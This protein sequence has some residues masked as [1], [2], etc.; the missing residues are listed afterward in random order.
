LESSDHVEER[1]MFFPLASLLVYVASGAPIEKDRGGSFLCQ[2]AYSIDEAPRGPVEPYLPQP[3]DIFLATDRS[4]IIR[5][6]HCLATSGAPHHSGIVVSRPDGSLGILEAGPFNSLRVAI[7]DLQPGLEK[8]QERGEKIWIRR[9]RT[10]L[11]PEQA[12]SL[13]AWAVAQDGKR[14]AAG[15]MLLQLTPIR[16]RGPLRTYVLGGPHGERDSY[17][18]SELV[19]ETCVH[20]GL[21]SP[22]TTRPTATYPRDLF[23]DQSSNLFL[24]A[25]FS[26]AHDWYPPALW[27]SEPVQTENVHARESP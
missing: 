7:V 27:T 4:K 3:G 11:A 19:L 24:N 21:L 16:S 2:P 6:G 20:I 5:A 1:V 13:T 25:H 26:L 23:F 17:F 10:P 14:F 15:R 18:C 22:S 9:R 8:H 12:A